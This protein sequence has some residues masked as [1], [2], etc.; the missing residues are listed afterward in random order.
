MKHRLFIM[1]AGLIV[2]MTM[3]AQ[4][5]K[6]FVVDDNLSPTEEDYRYL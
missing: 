4:K 6:T 1:A 3:Q 2:T 5:Q